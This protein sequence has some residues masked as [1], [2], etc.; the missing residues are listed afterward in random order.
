MGI[1]GIIFASPVQWG[2]EKLSMGWKWTRPRGVNRNVMETQSGV[3]T[4]IGI[5]VFPL[6]FTR[7]VSRAVPLIL[8][9]GG[10]FSLGPPG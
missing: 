9:L 6:A 4:D 8:G 10:A 3:C 1:L 7:R 5:L 2:E